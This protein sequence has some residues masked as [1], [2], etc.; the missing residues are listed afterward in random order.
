MLQDKVIGIYCLIDDILKG[1]NHC[2]HR[3]RKIS[4]REIITTAVV[5]ALYLKGNQ[6]HAR[7]Y[8]RSHNMMPAMIGKS[9][10]CKRLHKLSQLLLWMFPDIGGY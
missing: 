1:I 6:E 9:G 5:S 3:E 4:D 8:M 7:G 2:E 10:F